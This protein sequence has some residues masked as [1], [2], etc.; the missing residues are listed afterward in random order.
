MSA[1]KRYLGRHIPE[2]RNGLGGD[3]LEDR[4][5]LGLWLVDQELIDSDLAV[6]ADHVME[7]VER[8][9]WVVRHQ[10]CPPIQRSHDLAGVAPDYRTV[11]VQDLVP[12]AHLVDRAVGVPRISVLGDDP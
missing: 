8:F 11:L 2:C 1:N 4:E 12:S 10:C 5:L 6:P 9:P 7:G 3:L